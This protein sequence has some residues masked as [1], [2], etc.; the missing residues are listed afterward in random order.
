MAGMGTELDP[1]RIEVI[2]D[3]MAAIYRAMSGAQ[4]LKIASDL[5]ASARRMLASHLAA[6]HPDWDERQVG[7]ETARRLLGGTR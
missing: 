4:K 5:F 2:D 3:E 6:E 7:E 1:R